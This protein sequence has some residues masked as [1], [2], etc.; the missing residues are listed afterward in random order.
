MGAGFGQVAI[1]GGSLDVKE[2]VV[3]L[4]GRGCSHTVGFLGFVCLSLVHFVGIP[5]MKIHH[6]LCCCPCA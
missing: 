2:H 3:A 4:E 5:D 1:L 6:L